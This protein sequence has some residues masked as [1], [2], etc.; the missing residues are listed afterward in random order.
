MFPLFK[1]STQRSGG[2]PEQQ[3]SVVPMWL[4]QLGLKG[5]WHDGQAWPCMGFGAWELVHRWWLPV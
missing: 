3:F 4:V 1:C 5:A 2:V